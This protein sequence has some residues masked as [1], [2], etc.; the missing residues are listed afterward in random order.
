MDEIFEQLKTSL[1]DLG[2]KHNFFDKKV[3]IKCK[4]L[5]AVEA[6][7]NPEDQDYPI[8]KGKEVMIEAEFEGAKGQA[9]TDDY[10]NADYSISEII[11]MD[12]NS[13][14]KR[15]EFVAT[16]NAV[17]RYLGLCEKT[18]HC[19]DEEPRLCGKELLNVID[20]HKKILLIGLQPRLLESLVSR[21]SVRVID[22]DAD[23]IGKTKFGVV[24]E[25]DKKTKEAIQWCDELLVTGTTLVNNTIDQFL[26][27]GKPVRFF[28][29]T[30]SGPAVALNLN[31][32]C[33][34][35]H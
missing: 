6:I 10:G 21:Q 15:A 24:V 28:G 4:V 29:V 12:L 31:S 32:Y 33:S 30:I 2:K 1:N 5:S 16:F 19:R 18:I 11:N 14:R 22:L 35:G 20:H 13:N 8:I 27:T 34:Q 17:Y 25:D 23:N 26:N 7:G 3:N 9:F